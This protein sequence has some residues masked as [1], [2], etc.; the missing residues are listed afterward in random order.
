MTLKQAV[1]DHLVS[2]GM[3]EADAAT[4]FAAM[5]DSP[6]NEPMLGRWN[7]D[8]KNYPPAITGMAIVSAKTHALSWIEVNKPNAWY[9]PMFET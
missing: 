6:E 9:R 7:E 5:A 3:F 2:N 4:I 1:I 8:S